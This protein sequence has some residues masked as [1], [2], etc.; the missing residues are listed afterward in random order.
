[1]TTTSQ[2]GDD[3]RNALSDD[4][5]KGAGWEVKD[6]FELPEELA[7]KVQSLVIK[8]EDCY[9]VPLQGQPLSQTWTNN[10]RLVQD[11]I[12]GGS[13]ETAFRHLHDRVDVFNFEPYKQ[14]FFA[15]PQHS[16]KDNIKQALPTTSLK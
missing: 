3:F 2:H 16:W 11:H 6:D 7:Q 13:F 15:Y 12:R 4:T 9:N 8:S 5:A 14:A 1:M 10:S